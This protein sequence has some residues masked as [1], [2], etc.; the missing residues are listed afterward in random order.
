LSALHQFEHDAENFPRDGAFSP[1]RTG[2]AAASAG[3][4]HIGKGVSG[5]LN[6]AG[7]RL[8]TDP[9]RREG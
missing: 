1:S 2:R 6:R 3:S 4:R 8:R 7:G 5:A 9:N